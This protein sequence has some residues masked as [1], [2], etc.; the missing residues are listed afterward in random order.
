[1]ARYFF[2]FFFAAFFFAMV[3]PPSRSPRVPRSITVRTL[4]EGQKGVK[5]KNTG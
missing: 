1:M 2:F 5:G 4:G 3:S